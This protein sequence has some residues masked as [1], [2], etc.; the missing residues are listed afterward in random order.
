M[1]KK[2]RAFL[3][4]SGGGQETTIYLKV[5]SS[6]PKGPM[7]LMEK[8]KIGLSSCKVQI[9]LVYCIQYTTQQ[10]LLSYRVGTCQSAAIFTYHTI[11][12]HNAWRRIMSENKPW[13]SIS[14]FRFLT[15]NSWQ[16]T[17]KCVS[18]IILTIS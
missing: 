17:C 4:H 5:A 15:Y 9:K 2:C 6:W 10:T 8:Q 12:K 11:I 1:R 14:P 3:V 18:Y 16:C 7:K 13:L